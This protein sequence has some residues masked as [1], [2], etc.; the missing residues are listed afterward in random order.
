MSPSAQENEERYRLLIE[1]SRDLICELGREGHVRGIY[2]YVSP[3]YSAVLGYEPAELLNTNAFDLVHPDDLPDVISK[4][5]LESAT[6]TFRYRHKNGTWRWLECSGQVFRTSANEERGVIVSRDIT[7]RKVAEERLLDSRANL[8]T[9]Q[10]IMHVGSWEIDLINLEDVK[11][12]P[13]QWSDEVFRIFGYEPG[14]IEVSNDNFYRAV[15]PD[16]RAM[17]EAAVDEAIANHTQYSIDHRIIMPGGG[18]RIV[19]EE[20]QILYDEVT[21]KPLKMFGIVQDITERRHVETALRESQARWRSMAENIPDIIMTLDR[22]GTVLFINR[23]MEGFRREQIIGANLFRILPEKYRADARL[24]LDSLFDTGEIIHSEVEAPSAKSR[25]AWYSYRIGP[26]WDGKKIVAALLVLTDITEQKHTQE[27]QRESDARFRQIAENIEEVFWM[28]DHP[29]KSNLIYISPAYE[30]VWGRSLQSAHENPLSFIEAVHPEDRAR[31]EAALSK[32]AAGTYDEIYRIIRPD[33]T[34]RWIHDRA[35]PVHNAAGDVY[36]I[37]GLAE[38]ITERKQIEVQF[39]QS[40][41]MEAFGKLAGGVAHDFNNLLTVISGYNEIVLNAFNANDPRRD[42]VEEIGKAAERA[43][44]LTGQ[45]LAFSRQQVLQ[46]QVINLNTALKNVEKMLRRLIGEDIMLDTQP[47]E[48]LDCVKADPGQLEN[49][50]INLAVNARDAMPHG[51]TLT[52]K[53]EN[54]VVPHGDSNVSAG[55]YV[56]ISVA[57]TGIGMS[58]QVKSQIFEPFFTTKPVGHGTGLGLATCYGIVKQSDGFITV[59]SEVNKGTTFKIYLGGVEAEEEEEPGRVE[60]AALPHGNETIMVVEDEPNVRKLAVAV[61]QKL[62]YKVIEAANGEEAFHIAQSNIGGPLDLV[63]T[64]V[65]MPQMGGKDLALWIRAMYPETKVMFTSGYPNHA[66]DD[67]ELLQDEKS[68]FMAK[69]FSPK[70]LAVKV[71]EF[72]D[73]KPGNAP[74]HSS[75]EV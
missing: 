20:S 37:V 3:N 18:E 31:V 44:A 49:V 33:E 74:K 14:Q 66:F 67:S 72:I 60:P 62:G 55:K 57:D 22:E 7:E 36:R 9:A 15:H 30:K 40:Q 73:K 61:L 17:V 11:K 26:V 21:G 27:A 68:S 46:P 29:E 51:G 25:H 28:V 1:H 50:L 70:A 42:C 41:K 8:A 69:P 64:D 53:T 12:N 16:D 10:R 24:R 34:V 54:V 43:T 13:L 39:F 52:I 23:V 56:V 63:I 32:R 2:L 48:E 71:R 58:E 5:T 19:H 47:G 4:F 6:A 65:V 38:D 45:L 35:F 75:P 59:D